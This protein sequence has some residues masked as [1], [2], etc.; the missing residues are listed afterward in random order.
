MKMKNILIPSIIALLLS[1]CDL[2][3]LPRPSGDTHNSS[4]PTT[5]DG[6]IDETFIDYNLNKDRLG[7]NQL[8]IGDY[9]DYVEYS[10]ATMDGKPTA[11]L[12]ELSKSVKG[13]A[14][15]IFQTNYQQGLLNLFSYEKHIKFVIDISSTEIA[16]LER[17]YYK[18]NR[19]SYRICNLDI[20]MD[21]LHFHYEQVGI[22]QKGNTSRDFIR[23][24]DK[25]NLNHF[26]LSLEET[27]IDEYRDENNKWYSNA[28]K[29]YREDRK[30]F[31]ANKFNIRWNRN[32][33]KTYIREMYASEMYRDNGV[34]AARMNPIQV[35]LSLDGGETQNMGVYM[36]TEQINK[37]F[38]KRN[39]VSSA[40]G[41]DLYKLTW[42]RSSSGAS[43]RT[44]TISHIG[45][46]SQYWSDSIYV[47]NSKTYEIK[48]NEETSNYSV[49][50]NFITDLNNT[51]GKDSLTFMQNRSI[52][53][54]F[55]SFAA[56]SFILGDPDDLR[57]NS[58]NAYVYFTGDT[59]KIVF[60]PTDMDRVLGATGNTNGDNPTGNH[61]A[62]IGLYD[63]RTGY[64]NANQI[65]H[66]TIISSNA[67]DSREVY[68]SKISEA[69]N[70][71]WLNMDKFNSYYNV[72]K[73]LHIN[74]IHLGNQINGNELE[75]SL[76]ESEDLGGSYNLSVSKYL[77]EKLNVINSSI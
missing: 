10:D 5:Y 32:E 63:S 41:G 19:E 61:G 8:P 1:G 65:F 45:I 48:T 62:R 70:K 72:V 37:G 29:T 58:N 11:E 68:R 38:L 33:D 16:K 22:R 39:L 14:N 35:G 74:D 76:N 57:G 60:I 77:S 6:D 53:D 12:A 54:S 64:G 15:D 46:A 31:G 27:F 28:A 20:Y 49:L 55:Y 36:L 51:A 69:I 34:L 2:S 43:F 71:G 52:L 17:D 59:N 24:N 42:G 67:L 50:K 26:K 44:D 66:K 73:G 3:I 13:T 21:N 47:Q 75:F 25:I 23:E 30:F 56:C 9:G 7:D 18:R 4:E 40:R